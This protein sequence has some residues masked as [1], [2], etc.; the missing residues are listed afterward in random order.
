MTLTELNWQTTMPDSESSYSRLNKNLQ[1]TRIESNTLRRSLDILLMGCTY[2]WL[3]DLRKEGR[4]FPVEQLLIHGKQILELVNTITLPDDADRQ[5]D[6]VFRCS[7]F[8]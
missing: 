2:G 4:F 6:Y 3:Q 1:P 5:L 7:H 8:V